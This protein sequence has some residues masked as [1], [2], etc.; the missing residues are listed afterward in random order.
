M[1]LYLHLVADYIG[2]IRV[3]VLIAR[4]IIVDDAKFTLPEKERLK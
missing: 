2:K 3:G 1:K 4:S